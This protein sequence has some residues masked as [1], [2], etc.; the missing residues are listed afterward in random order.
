MSS[1]Q[2]DLIF[3]LYEYRAKLTEE[4]VP[5][6]TYIKISPETIKSKCELN[7]DCE[8][9]SLFESSIEKFIEELYMRA[10]YFSEK[11]I[12]REDDVRM[13]ILSDPIYDFLEN[14]AIENSEDCVMEKN[15]VDI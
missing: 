4:K 14:Y 6:A 11:D 8:T 9:L 10:Y 12:I 15:K 2:D 7:L 1:T 5:C 13:A 3:K